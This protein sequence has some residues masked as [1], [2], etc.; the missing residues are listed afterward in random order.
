MRFMS[1]P[2]P[3]QDGGTVEEAAHCLGQRGRFAR[4]RLP[5]EADGERL[6]TDSRGRLRASR[7]RRRTRRGEEAVLIHVLQPPPSPLFMCSYSI[8]RPVF[9]LIF[10]FFNFDSVRTGAATIVI[11][12]R[13]TPQRWWFHLLIK[14]ETCPSLSGFNE[15]QPKLVNIWKEVCLL[16]LLNHCSPPLPVGRAHLIAPQTRGRVCAR[17][18]GRVWAV[19]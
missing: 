15:F 17:Q 11:L 18:W 1:C 7:S 14:D 9:R 3:V 16:S 10:F 4:W 6:W 19:P 8:R 2:G 13:N 12:V 5:V